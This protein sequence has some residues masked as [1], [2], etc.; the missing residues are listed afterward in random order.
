LEFDRRCSRALHARSVF[1]FDLLLAPFA[2][3]CGMYGIV[4]SRCRRLALVALE[5]DRRCSRALHS[6]SVFPFDLLLAPFAMVCGMYGM[7]L[8]LPIVAYC[9]NERLAGVMLMS[10]SVERRRHDERSHQQQHA[11]RDDDTR[12]PLSSGSC[13]FDPVPSVAAC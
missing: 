13:S 9:E 7:P 11:A 4:A 6:R 12:S 10:V 1:P 5:F 2:M 3:V 8:V